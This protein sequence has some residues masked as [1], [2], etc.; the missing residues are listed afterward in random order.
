MLANIRRELDRLI[1]RTE[2]AKFVWVSRAIGDY[3]EK[4][5]S[6]ANV[7]HPQPLPP[8]LEREIQRF[9]SNSFDMQ[10]F[11]YL[12]IADLALLPMSQG[13]RELWCL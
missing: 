12:T 3:I 4:G 13:R 8:H 7:W 1:D 9:S 6:L 10:H 11:L 5:S 2:A